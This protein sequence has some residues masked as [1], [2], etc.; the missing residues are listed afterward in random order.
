M[1][2]SRNDRAH[3]NGAPHQTQD[4]QRYC[5]P[6]RAWYTSQTRLHSALGYRTQGEAEHDPVSSNKAAR[7]TQST[8]ARDTPS[9]P[10]PGAWSGTPLYAPYL[11]P[12]RT[13]LGRGQEEHRQHPGSRTQENW[14]AGRVSDSPESGLSGCLSYCS[15]LLL[16][17]V[18]RPVPQGGVESFLIVFQLDPGGNIPDGLASCG[19]HHLI[20]PLVP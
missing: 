10:P 7:P 4:H 14:I 13:C 19:I 9:S 6:G 11:W 17:L 12:R 1:R 16:N 15:V 18:G 8:T 2:P 3:T 5:L 20:D